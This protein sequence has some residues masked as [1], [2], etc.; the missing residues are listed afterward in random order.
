MVDEDCSDVGRVDNEGLGLV[1]DDGWALNDGAGS[2]R[3]EAVDG[4]VNLQ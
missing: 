3:L 2:E 4:S 1:E